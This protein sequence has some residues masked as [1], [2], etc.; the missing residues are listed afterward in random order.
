[1]SLPLEAVGSW[2]LICTRE[3]R[4]ASQRLWLLRYHVIMKFGEL[5]SIAHNI[6]DS[7]PSGIGLLIGFYDMNIFHRGRPSR[8]RTRPM[9]RPKPKVAGGDAR[10]CGRALLGPKSLLR[11]GW[12]DLRAPRSTACEPCG[13]RSQ[14]DDTASLMPA[15]AARASPC[16]KPHAWVGQI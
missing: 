1:M 16:H 11:S 15:L 6:A 10:C 2:P 12:E 4:S 3:K 13:W 9:V 8:S 5:R 14:C 7:L